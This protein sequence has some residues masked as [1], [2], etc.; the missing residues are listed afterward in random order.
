[1]YNTLAEIA[2]KDGNL[3][4]A[5]SYRREERASYATAPVSQEALRRHR[6]LVE[7]VVEAV[8][9][10][11][12]RPA[13][14]QALARMGEHGWAKLVEALRLILDGER[15]ED[16]LCELLDGEDSLVVGAVLRGIGDPAALGQLGAAEPDGNDVQSAEFTSG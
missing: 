3:E 10:P 1:M 16:A 15:D 9:E 2:G 6:A 4:V 14:D 12:H 13:L 7:S 5:R 11:S 8:G